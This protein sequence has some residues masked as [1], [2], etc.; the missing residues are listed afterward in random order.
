[1]I[2]SSYLLESRNPSTKSTERKRRRQ[3]KGW[4]QLIYN[5]VNQIKLNCTDN[6][7]IIYYETKRKD[8]TNV[9]LED[10][11]K[12]NTTNVA[13]SGKSMDDLLPGD[14]A[15]SKKPLMESNHSD[16]LRSSSSVL[17][18]NINCEGNND[19]RFLTFSKEYNGLIYM[20]HI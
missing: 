6:W 11:D 17:S 2:Y 20:H 1:M 8:L 5:F 10:D 4:V 9:S 12:S 15:H 16:S 3:P 14:Q 18:S 7:H 19:L 13:Y